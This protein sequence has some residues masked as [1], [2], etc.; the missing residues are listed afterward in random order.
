[1]NRYSSV[2]NFEAERQHKEACLKYTLIAAEESVHALRD[3]FLR[4]AARLEQEILAL[5]P[6]SEKAVKKT[7][8]KRRRRG[9]ASA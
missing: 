9:K 4:Q 1:M 2:V 8:L 3:V 5:T 7:K 6:H